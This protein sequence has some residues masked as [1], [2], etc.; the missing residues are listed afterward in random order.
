MSSLKVLSLVGL[1]LAIILSNR[2]PPQKK[3]LG[4]LYENPSDYYTPDFYEGGKDLVL[5]GGKMRYWEFGP[6]DG[7]KVIL[8]HG[9]STGSSVYNKVARNLAKNNHRVLIFDLWGRGYSEAPFTYYDDTLYTN[10]VAL[11]LQKVGWT[12]TNVIGVSLGGGI[13]TSF[14]SF[15]P[16]MVDKLVLL[17]PTGLMSEKDIPFTGK[18]ARLPFIRNIILHPIVRPIAILGVQRFFKSS[19]STYLDEETKKIAAYAL[20]QFTHHPGF[21]RAFLGT[22]MDFPF[23]GLQSRYESIGEDASKQVLVIWGDAD[24]T[25]PFENVHLLKKYIPQAQI[26]V[27]PGGGHDVLVSCAKQVS[28][29]INKF[30][31][32]AT[33]GIISITAWPTMDSLPNYI[34]KRNRETDDEMISSSS[35]VDDDDYQPLPGDHYP[36]GVGSQDNSLPKSLVNS[37]ALRANIS[38]FISVELLCVIDDQFCIKV[39][40]SFKDAAQELTHVI[41]LKDNI[42]IRAAYYEFCDHSC[43]NNTFG[44]GAPS[45]QFTLPFKDDDMDFLYPQAL[46][47]QLSPY[48]HPSAWATHDILIELNHDPYMNA[49]HSETVRHE[50]N[51]GW[52]GT[53]IPPFGKYWFKRDPEIKSYQIDFQYIILHE[54]LHGLGFISS[55]AAYFSNDIS[56]FRTLLNEV[57]DPIDLQLVTPSLYWTVQAPAGPTFVTGFQPTMIFDKFLYVHSDVPPSSF[58]ENDN[59]GNHTNKNKSSVLLSNYTSL[60]ELG[61]NMQDYCVQG[62]EAFIINFVQSFKKSNQSQQSHQLYSMLSQGHPLTFEFGLP[63]ITTSPTT[64]NQVLNSLIH[65][66]QSGRL[67]RPGI[68]IAHLDDKLHNT[69]DFIM[70]TTYQQ[71]KTLEQI[72]DEV[73]KNVPKINYQHIFNK[74]AS[75]ERVYKS[76]I[77]P[78]ILRILDIMGYTTALSDANDIIAINQQE[79]SQQPQTFSHGKKKKTYNHRNVCDDMHTTLFGLRSSKST[80]SVGGTSNAVS[81]LKKKQDLL[82]LLPASSFTWTLLIIIIVLSGGY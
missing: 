12:K 37:T 2:S 72:V 36:L 79:P 39:F 10:Q 20:H 52:N 56:P 57:F 82:L 74:T 19:R 46:A 8:I 41:H 66:E 64:G 4:S 49:I 13:A 55:W 23:F 14:A 7:K 22:V 6:K 67:F 69:P 77:G 29:D 60:M 70:T 65:H 21:L 30:L 80:L 33:Y 58:L 68:M 76:P 5:P 44:L 51:N 71:G 11:L 28:E 27:Y 40:D 24:K 3:T 32:N 53:G 17:A 38:E 50:D 1:V 34:T 62:Y 48:K 47:K 59:D 75:I 73:Y 25:V 18:L 9:I 61:F 63:N 45:S 81:G 15:Y 43:A 42:L 54:I 78:G 26:E 35:I 16:E 31:T